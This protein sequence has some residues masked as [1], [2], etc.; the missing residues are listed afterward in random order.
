MHI[1]T[2]IFAFIT[3]A[4]YAATN[5]EEGII[6]A[7]IIRNHDPSYA[8]EFAKKRYQLLSKRRFN[9]RDP[10][11]AN[12]YNDQ[13]SQYLVEVGIG[14]PPQKF[15]VTLDTGSADLWVPSTECPSNACPFSRFSAS[16]SSSFKSLNQNFGIQ[17]GIGNV[18]GTYATDTVTVGGATVSNQQ[19]GLATF[20][21]DILQPNPSAGGEGSSAPGFNGSANSNQ[22]EANGILGLGY[23]ALTQANSQGG[24]AYNPFVFNLVSQNLI[25]EPIFSIYLNSIS[26]SGWSGEIIFGGVDQSKFEGNLT[27]LPVAGLTSRRSSALGG[28]NSKFYYWMVY[29]Q[30]L[31]VQ[32]ANHGSNPYWNLKEMGAFILDT[33]TTLTYLPTSVATEIVSAFAGSNGYA[34]DRSSGVFAVDC[35]T[36]NSPARFELQ[37]STSSSRS[38]S[39]IV[40]SVPASELVIPLDSNDVSTASVCMFGI[41]PLG[42]SGSI[43]ANMYLVGDSVLR[44]AY[45]VFDMGQ[46]RVGLAASKGIGGRISVGNSTA[47]G[48]NSSSG[49]SSSAGSVFDHSMTT[50]ITLAALV[51]TAVTMSS[52]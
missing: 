46:N 4:V 36:A 31:G 8:L 28:N 30:G 12:L 24:N 37:M 20:T 10:F 40:L 7:P 33:G 6:R 15:I 25:K 27:Y 49:T 47:S 26:K 9:K 5:H 21:K 17:Y 44:S 14:T 48:S 43:G 16:N 39:P 23:P 22:I 18:N 3:T 50:S 42:G 52:F 29:G 34:L 35:N 45:M 13:G 41:A 32:N 38:S 2:A 51:L 19:F 11:E 1:A